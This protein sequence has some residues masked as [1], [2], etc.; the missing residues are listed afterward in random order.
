[1]GG[2]AC[3]CTVHRVTVKVAPICTL[4]RPLSEA[5]GSRVPRRLCPPGHAGHARWVKFP[6]V[7]EG[8]SP[9]NH[10]FVPSNH[11]GW[12]AGFFF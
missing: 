11:R 2:K 9:E 10:G 8:Q 5:P 6:L 3:V 4:D 1:M 7:T 12:G